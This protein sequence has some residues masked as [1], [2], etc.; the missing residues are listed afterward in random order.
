[1]QTGTLKVRVSF[2]NPGNRLRAGMNCLVRV[3]NS[4]A[5]NQLTIP[6]KALTEQLGEFFVYVMGDSNK[7]VQR[8][9]SVG[10]RFNEMVVIR[11]G[12]KEGEQIVSDGVQNLRPGAVVNPGGQQ[13]GEAAGKDSSAKK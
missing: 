3:A 6:N 10:S 9:V 13:A 4:D 5:G 12:L 2:P 7:V 8:R 1:A 11:D